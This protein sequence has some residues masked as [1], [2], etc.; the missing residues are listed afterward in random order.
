LALRAHLKGTHSGIGTVIGNIFYYGETRPTI[1]AV[2]ER[3]MVAPV[4]RVEN[5][6]KAS[7]AGGNIWRNQLILAFLS[8]AVADFEPF[9]ICGGM[10]GDRNAFY[11]G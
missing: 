2:G 1:G 10:I 9:V 5:L 4:S 3:V 7:L 8:D 11:T 6:L